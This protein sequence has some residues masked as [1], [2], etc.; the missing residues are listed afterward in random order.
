MFDNAVDLPEPEEAQLAFA[1][2]YDG[3]YGV[4]DLMKKSPE[5]ML[6]ILA[7]FHAMTSKLPTS[8]QVTFQ[9][10]SSAQSLDRPGK[11]PLMRSLG[12]F[13]HKV[14]IVRS[15]RVESFSL[16]ENETIRW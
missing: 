10:E 3:D 14:I 11:T 15:G 4:V 8:R 16:T 6:A 1:D 13:E 7:R 2:M 5:L 9:G 12:S